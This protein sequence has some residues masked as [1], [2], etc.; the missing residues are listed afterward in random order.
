MALSSCELLHCVVHYI[1]LLSFVFCDATS[2]SIIFQTR[3]MTEFNAEE[4]FRAVHTEWS[5][6][7]SLSL[8]RFFHL[9]HVTL[10]QRSDPWD[11]YTSI[12]D[13]IRVGPLRFN[14][15]V[16]FCSV[17]VNPV[18]PYS[19]HPC[20]SGLGLTKYSRIFKIK[21]SQL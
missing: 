6:S 14:I 17:F 3:Y 15:S 11:F 12:N 1:N 8:L 16:Y 5:Y 13:F 19:W 2:N 18:L 7:P 20:R 10:Y 4:E 21:K 9:N